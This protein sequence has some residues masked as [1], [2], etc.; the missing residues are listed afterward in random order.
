MNILRPSP[1]FLLKLKEY[2]HA[3]YKTKVTI[4]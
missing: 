1:G 4:V 3:I 2:I